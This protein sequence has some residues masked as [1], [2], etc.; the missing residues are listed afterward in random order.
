[1]RRAAL[2]LIISMAAVSSACAP[3]PAPV[4][5]H[6]AYTRCPRPAAP[7]LPAIDPGQHLCAPANLERLLERADVVKASSEDMHWID[8]TRTPEQI[9]T[10]WLALGP[11]IVVV[12]FGGVSFVPGEIA[13]SDDDGIVVT[14][15]ASD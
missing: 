7:E 14:D 6:Q 4:T 9:A 12:T 2:L 1:M 5:V 10:S 8:P 11:S 15:G 13:Y 3:T